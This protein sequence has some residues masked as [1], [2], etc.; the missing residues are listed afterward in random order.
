MDI[1]QHTKSTIL[2][3]PRDKQKKNG[4][5]RSFTRAL[6]QNKPSNKNDKT[7]FKISVHKTSKS[8]WEKLKT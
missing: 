8:C 3:Y 7:M 1:G 5:K 6:K 4:F 2:L